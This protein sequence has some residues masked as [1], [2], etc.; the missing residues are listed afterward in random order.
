MDEELLFRSFRI[1][2]QSQKNIY[3]KN[4]G[5]IA[6]PAWGKRRGLET[7]EHVQ[8]LDPDDEEV[9]QMLNNLE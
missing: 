9:R 4:E 8:R 3:F 7:W 2:V 6:F 5:L 1:D